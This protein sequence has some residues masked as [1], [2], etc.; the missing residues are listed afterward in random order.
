MVAVTSLNAYPSPGE[1]S[2]TDAQAMRL[3]SGVPN[4]TNIFIRARN[5]TQRVAVMSGW[6]GAGKGDYL[7]SEGQATGRM[8]CGTVTKANY[9]IHS[10]QANL[11]KQYRLSFG[12]KCWVAEGDSGGPVWQNDGPSA[13][14]INA[15]GII[16]QLLNS[17]ADPCSPRDGYKRGH[18]MEFG[19]YSNALNNLGLRAYVHR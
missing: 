7:C 18:A 3:V 8:S 16:E 4:S 6:H 5:K 14:H 12:D 19:L 11:D 2:S 9:K 1:T 10:S 17:R 13:L 15:V